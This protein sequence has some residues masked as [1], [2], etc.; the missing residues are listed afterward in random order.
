MRG[1]LAEILDLIERIW[2][3]NP[4]LRF[5]QLIYILQSGYSQANSGIGR[6]EEVIDRDFSITGFDLFNLEDDLFVEYLRAVV[7]GA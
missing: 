1:Q 7:S 3:R 2:S 5:N 6:V 4:D